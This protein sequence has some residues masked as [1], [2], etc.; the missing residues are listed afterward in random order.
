MTRILA[1]QI[2]TQHGVVAARQRAREIAALLGFEPHDQTRLATAVS[3]IA[4]NAFEYGRGGT[5]EFFVSGVSN[6]QSFL[7]RITDKGRGIAN[8]QDI[9]DGNFQ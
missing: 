4:R 9:L 3:E 7:I 8:L 6:P 2:Q 1:V 5:A